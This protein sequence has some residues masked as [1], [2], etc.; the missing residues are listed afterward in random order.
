MKHF[1]KFIAAAM[2]LI[3][4]T[5]Y[6]EPEGG[7]QYTELNPP[8]PVSTG[9][10]IEVLE[11]FFYGCIHCF[12]LHPALSAWE[13]KMPKD[14]SI[15]YVPTIFQPSWEPMAY[16]FYALEAMGA[17]KKLDDKLYDA[18]NVSHSFLVKS[19]EIADF[20]AKN[21]LDRQKFLD[22]Y[23]SFSVQSDVKRSKQM[24]LQYHIEGTPTL[25]VDGKYVISGLEPE[26]AIRVLNTLIKQARM[27][28]GKR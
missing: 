23:N 4:A 24:M 17:R 18:W 8:Q 6:A 20:M 16:T 7:Q 21:G 25:I 11:F 10:K 3:T 26:V 12:H 22:Y 9:S 14:V 15:E 27:E 1:L 19:D 28:R 13:K 2:L 5:A